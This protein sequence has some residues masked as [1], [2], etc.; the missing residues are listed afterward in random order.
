MDNLLVRATKVYRHPKAILAVALVVTVVLA[1][2]I[3]FLKFDNNIRNMLPQ[4]N[5]DLKVHD[6]YEDESRFGSSS[7]VF[8]GVKSDDV[9]SDASLKYLKT[10]QLKLEALNQSLPVANLGKLLGLSAE[11]AAQL[12]EGIRGLGVNEQNYGDQL[13]P[14]LV[15]PAQLAEKFGFD[16]ALAAKVASAAKR[17]APE[18]VYANFEEPIHKLESL[19]GADSIAS[20]DDSLVVEKLL[21][22]DAITVA[23]DGSMT[24][25]PGTAAKLKAKVDSWE[26][27]Q[28]VLVSQDGKMGTMVVSLNT[29][30]IGVKASLNR[31][32]VK[33]LADTATPGLTTYLDG[34]TVIEDKIATYMTDDLKVLLPLVTLVIVLILYFCFRK[35]QGVVY[36]GVVIIMGVI[37]AVGL[38]AWLGIPVSVVGTAM[39]VLLVA[40]ASAYGIHQMNH[41]LLDASH[42]KLAILTHNMKTV[43]LAILLS[44]ITVMVGFGSLLTSD[45]VPVRNFG[46][47]TAFGDLVAVVASLFVLP[48]LILAGKK[49][50]VVEYHE[51]EKGLVSRILQA[52]VTLN[53]KHSVAVIVASAALTAVFALGCFSVKAELNNVSM[54]KADDSTAIADTVLNDTLAGTQ[55]LNV[56]LDSDLSDVVGRTGSPEESVD[57]TTP[58][59]LNKIEA[60]NA[61][62]VQ[63]FPYVTKTLSFNTMIKKM[64]QEMTGGDP[65]QYAIPQDPQLISQYLLIFSGDLQ[66]VLSANH[67]KLRVSVTMKRTSTDESEKVARFALAFFDQDF[68]KANHVQVKITGAAHLYYVANTLLING[69][70]NSV[71]VCVAIVFLLLLV[72]LRDFWISLIAMIPIFITL[73]INYGMLG[74]FNIPLNAGTAMV[75]TVA[76]GIGVDY[77]IHYITWYRREIRQRRD[78]A[79]ALEQTIVHKGRAILYNMLV[80]VGGFLVMVVSKF[81]P[82]IQFGVLVSVCMVTTAVGSLVI[83]PAVMNLLSRSKKEKSFLYMNSLS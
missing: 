82:L 27:Y 54:F 69:T 1:S 16:A 75:S 55:V 34:E 72:V 48:A 41:Y 45:F 43:G 6:Y 80:I 60:F 12:V 40:I 71:L 5:V 67:D 52:F 30:E 26:I 53:K 64:N 21:D 33:L 20:R 31:S 35:V 19:V 61:A 49:P 44:G 83:V 47:L 9:Y 23:A 18:L 11:E 77:S 32:L 78:I 50:K 51:A 42:D 57:V 37:W 13:I 15:D 63:Q 8:I 68:Q 25:A 36:P 17:V 58:A 2:A 81:V 46:I 76:V 59:V 65:A 74:L 3:P 29:H 10:L 39:P 38:E 62:V 22:E 24:V 73:V 66:S 28:G 14:V 56:V 70:I 7:Y 79:F 4:H